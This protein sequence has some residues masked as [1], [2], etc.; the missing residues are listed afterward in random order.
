MMTMMIIRTFRVLYAEKLSSACMRWV[1]ICFATASIA[2]VV[3]DEDDDFILL[4]SV[5]TIS[6]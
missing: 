5:V 4:R 1:G 3:N 2:K 6:P